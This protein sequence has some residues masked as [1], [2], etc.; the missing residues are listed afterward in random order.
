MKTSRF[1]AQ[2]PAT[3]VAA[4]AGQSRGEIEADIEAGKLPGYIHG[5]RY[6][7]AR[8]DFLEKVYPAYIQRLRD[9]GLATKTGDTPDP[10]SLAA[11]VDRRFGN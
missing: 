5:N 4:Y 8:E 11:L 10:A 3:E 1:R 6:V 9:I 7:M 2:I